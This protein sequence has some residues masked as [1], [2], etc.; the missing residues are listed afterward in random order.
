MFVPA[1]SVQAP[2][3]GSGSQH[4]ADCSHSILL[5]LRQDL[6]GNDTTDTHALSK[7][8]GPDYT[9][10]MQNPNAVQALPRHC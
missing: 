2:N 3:R 5:R 4:S 1:T 10:Y 9:L 6:D 7:W 8:T